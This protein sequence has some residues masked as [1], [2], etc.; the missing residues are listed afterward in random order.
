MNRPAHHSRFRLEALEP[1]ILL[2][3][4]GLAG[5]TLATAGPVTAVE[6]LQTNKTASAATAP[7]FNQLLSADVAQNPRSAAAQIDTIFSAEKEAAPAEK[8]APG[9]DAAAPVA[10]S[11]K[12][13]TP[14]KSSE[15]A[16]PSRCVRC[17]GVPDQNL[18]P[19]GGDARHAQ[20][21]R[22]PFPLSSCESPQCFT[23][24]SQ[25]EQRNYATVEESL[26]RQWWR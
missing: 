17:V 3:G 20:G 7:E 12:D 8:I 9:V 5:A 21:C 4:D 13:A 1:R 22:S 10:V 14:E 23:G 15:S 26:R 16:T 19:I 2:S 6:V 24:P 18:H 25:W 11:E